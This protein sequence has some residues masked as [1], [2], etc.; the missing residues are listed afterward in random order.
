MKI[1]YS[2]IVLCILICNTFVAQTTI[3]DARAAGAGATITTKGIVT[4]GQELGVIRYLQDATGGLA[5]YDTNLASTINRG[6]S[7]LVTGVL[8]DFNGLLEITLVSN[9]VILNSGNTLPEPFI[10]T[11]SQIVEAT[12]GTL[13]RINQVSFT[14]AGGTF[15]GNT[16]YTFQASGE[17]LSIYVRNG[18]PLVGQSIP[19]GQ[20][21]MVGLSSQYLANYQILPR[22]MSDF[23]TGPGINITSAVTQTGLT[24]IGFTLNW[25]TDITG[26]SGVRYGLTTALEM[27]E[28]SNGNMST[29]HSFP[30]FG[31]DAGQIYYCRAFSVAGSD[32]AFAPVRPFGVVSNSSGTILSY[33]NTSVDNSVA[34]N[35]NA[36]ELLEAI[37]DTLIAYINRAEVSL[38]L[39]IYDFI[40]DGV[41]NISDAI[42]AAADR[43]VQVRFI[44]DGTLAATNTAI[45]ELNESVAHLY[46]PVGDAY[47]IM[48]NKFV[49]IDANHSDPM[50]PLVWTGSTNWTERQLYTDNNSVIIVQDQTLARAYT[51]E[52][53]E[54]WGS[55]GPI[56]DTT[57]SRF[58]SF[59]LDNNP[60]E[61]RIGNKRVESYFSPS[62]NVNS[63]LIET[64][65]TAEANAYFA[66]MLI[67]R[68]DVAQALVDKHAAGVTVQGIINDPSSTS[69]YG[70][71]SAEL[72]AD[73]FINSDTSI[74]MHH[75]HLIV[76]HN[77][78]SSDPLLWVGSHN[79][80]TNANTRND[81][82][83]LIVHDGNIANQYYQEFMSLI[84]FE[85]VAG[86]TDASACNFN[87]VAS[88]DDGSCLFIA[89]PCDDGDANTIN[90]SVNLSCEC[91][92][93]IAV[94]GCT[95]IN[96][97]NFSLEA[98]VEDNS[99]LFE[100]SP[101]DDGNS[102]TLNDMI[103][104][105]CLCEGIVNNVDERELNNALTCFPNPASEKIV[106]QFN[107]I[108][109]GKANCIIT[110]SNGKICHQQ[111][112]VVS[113]GDNTIAFEIGFLA[114]G[115][116]HISIYTE[117]E[118]AESTFL[119]K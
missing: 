10:Y 87:S 46:S 42:N 111:E 73:L 35:Q 8:A 82:N 44:S 50:K 21:D 86:C 76:D 20:T 107:A 108:N 74:I 51:M 81:E 1:K 105:S 47:N 25:T 38:D 34:T 39:T 7:V 58:G 49:I 4:N 112:Y 91:L 79:W 33:F 30:L 19:G 99:C 117:L 52:F 106:V 90:D 12:E 103:N 56:P 6:D 41:S 109:S 62:D 32:T 104:S 31:V 27:G 84:A 89:N 55:S 17:S 70:I 40:N 102:E 18:S 15:A 66:S 80:S 77:V 63:K 16:S 24:N 95:D 36:V 98:N 92:G 48:H 26:N 64:I 118:K 78:L 57:Q 45:G 54:M 11:P 65:N 116:Y 110:D 83:T 101:C 114:V 93:V 88:I 9:L 94:L 100:G 61:F 96:A 28:Q 72:G 3:I 69:Q 29:N 113:G 2:L 5:I 14:N 67:T 43:G 97:C 68:N 115:Q 119:K 71:L 75:K 23:I 37:D 13:V 53:N 60:H 59:K 22:D 85:P